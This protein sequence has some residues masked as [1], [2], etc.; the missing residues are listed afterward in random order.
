MSKQIIYFDE[1]SE[2]TEAQ[3]KEM[4]KLFRF[5]WWSP[6]FLYRHY[7][8]RNSLLRHRAEWIISTLPKGKL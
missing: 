3:W 7:I 4:D 5:R 2:M 8:K 1:V 6:K